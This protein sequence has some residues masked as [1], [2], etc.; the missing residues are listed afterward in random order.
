[1]TMLICLPAGI[2]A[3]SSKLQIGK[4]VDISSPELAEHAQAEGL[5]K[6]ENGPLDFAQAFS[7]DYAGISLSEKQTP[8]NRLNFINTSLKTINGMQV[9]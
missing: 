2:L 1:M 8:E 4:D 7:A 3:T 9:H 6:E 5:W